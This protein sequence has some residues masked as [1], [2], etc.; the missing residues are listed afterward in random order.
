MSPEQCQGLQLDHRSDIYSLGIVVFEMLTG[1]RPFSAD[2]VMKLFNLHVHQ[3]PPT[4]SS[5]R[6]DLKF[7]AELESV[8]AQALAKKPQERQ[9]SIKEFWQALQQSCQ[10]FDF[11]PSSGAAVTA[12][13]QSMKSYSILETDR[14][15]DATT[16]TGGSNFAATT[17]GHNYLPASSDFLEQEIAMAEQQLNRFKPV[18]DNASLPKAGSKSEKSPIIASG[19]EPNKESADQLRKSAKRA[20]ESFKAAATAFDAKPHVD[21]TDENNSTVSDQ[22]SFDPNVV[23]SASTQSAASPQ[24]GDA[25]FISTQSLDL[26][27]DMP[28]EDDV[29]A[30]ARK[31]L[32][33]GDRQAEKAASSGSSL[34]SLPI[35]DQTDNATAGGTALSSDTVSGAS[36]EIQGRELERS[37]NLAEAA[38]RLM[39][40]LRKQPEMSQSG[41]H[42]GAPSEADQAKPG[43]NGPK[44]T[45]AEHP[46][47]PSTAR[48]VNREP[49]PSNSFAKEVDRLLDLSILPKQINPTD[50]KAGA[51]KPRRFE[52]PVNNAAV[53]ASAFATE[54]DK[55][56][57]A[58]ILKPTDES[59]VAPNVVP[60][61]QAGGTEAAPNLAAQAA[62]PAPE[63]SPAQTSASGPATMA[64]S[65]TT[66]KSG[67]SAKLESTAKADGTSAQAN[68]SGVGASPEQAPVPPVAKSPLNPRRF[69]EPVNKQTEVLNPFASEVEKLIDS[70]MLKSMPESVASPSDDSP[71]P[72]A[73]LAE[74][75]TV[76]AQ[77]VKTEIG[78]TDATTARSN[79]RT[80]DFVSEQEETRVSPLNKDEP[81]VDLPATAEA[82]V[83]D[84]LKVVTDISSPGT[85]PSAKPYSREELNAIPSP[86]NSQS[87]LASLS[88]N[89]AKIQRSR[90]NMDSIGGVT[91]AEVDSTK[92]QTPDQSGSDSLPSQPVLNQETT[93]RPLAQKGN[94]LA[95]GSAR[96]GD[97]SISQFGKVP[98]EGKKLKSSFQRRTNS[99]IQAAVGGVVGKLKS[100]F[101]GKATNV[102]ASAVRS[103]AKKAGFRESQTESVVDRQPVQDWVPSVGGERVDTESG[104]ISADLPLEDMVAPAPPSVFSS[105]SS[106]NSSLDEFVALTSHSDFSPPHPPEFDFGIKPELEPTILPADNFVPERPAAGANQLGDQNLPSSSDSKEEPSIKDLLAQLT[107]RSTKSK[108]PTISNEPPLGSG[109]ATGEQPLV[110]NM[111]E[112][113]VVDS[114]KSAQLGVVSG[115][116]TFDQQE[117]ANQEQS[118]AQE[119]I[120]QAGAVANSSAAV[121]AD[122]ATANAGANDLSSGA[123]STAAQRLTDIADRFERPISER[124]QKAQVSPDQGASSVPQGGYD[125]KSELAKR[126]DEVLTTGPRPAAAPGSPGVKPKQPAANVDDRKLDETMPRPGVESGS[127]ASGLASKVDGLKA[128]DSISR[129]LEAAK[130]SPAEIPTAGQE[131]ASTAS[132]TQATTASGAGQSEALNKKIEAVKKKIEAL[133]SGADPGKLSTSGES[134]LESKL[135][136]SRADRSATTKNRM[137]EAAQKAVDVGSKNKMASLQPAAG[138]ASDQVA[139]SDTAASTPDA[140]P[141]SPDQKV[142]SAGVDP[143]ALAAQLVSQAIQKRALQN[144]GEFEEPG[145]FRNIE[146]TIKSER[147]RA[148]KGSTK[149]RPTGARVR[150]TFAKR[151]IG[152]M[153]GLFFTILVVAA[154]VIYAGQLIV[155]QLTAM[156]PPA[157]TQAPSIDALIN[158]NKLEQARAILDAQQKGPKFS[159]KDADRY[160]KIAKRYADFKQYEDAIDVLSKFDRRSPSY[161]QARKL[162]KL[163]N[164][165]KGSS[166]SK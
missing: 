66:A 75:T 86:A 54:V 34:D 104:T 128:N 108:L 64:K 65:D 25:D 122:A 89:A 60:N 31:V 36:A 63:S 132:G 79:Q 129:L 71:K 62:A 6:P 147:A 37:K 99:G 130:R 158:A 43:N 105:T 9:T 103:K 23:N 127:G 15:V 114:E 18:A 88:F 123:A 7:P 145:S 13:S 162:L 133:K 4:L 40:V 138:G 21:Q 91:G 50:A 141:S 27:V 119:K 73:A 161:R 12:E 20:T 87:G 2:G 35:E 61:E 117:T 107:K 39:G 3:T 17:G 11:V 69:E 84:A 5:V 94:G 137:L 42:P 45:E 144:E 111:D 118:L 140:S 160:I 90:Q 143:S 19:T 151:R 30:W 78:Q 81:A 95:A 57:D 8:L 92:P 112:T 56:L 67:S 32:A 125:L 109:Q 26:P 159:P 38:E 126:L 148:S 165:L 135:A 16:T 29:S 106:G 68:A 77:A 134:K 100:I 113:A 10:N 82:P 46:S 44:K 150:S 131:A 152:P 52:D 101:G 83:S 110:P 74:Q 136:G 146:A 41:S 102:E 124:T 33:N 149:E 156:S 166:L 163:Y 115:S 154:L 142:S 85:E 164:G 48:S 49:D 51:P 58:A 70:A 59:S 121:T 24:K 28:A 55:V 76:G 1:I 139:A 97:A 157:S 53:L 96:P 47:A 116:A 80:D 72:G 22:L 93:D 153:I 120:S 155:D 14:L 98:A